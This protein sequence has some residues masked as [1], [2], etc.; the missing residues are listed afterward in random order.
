M[1]DVFQAFQT[2]L[3]GGFDY[4]SLAV[5]YSV[6][7]IILVLVYKIITMIFK[8]ILYSFTKTKKERSNT[9]VFFHLWRYVYIA[10]SILILMFATTGSFEGLGY[11]TALLSAAIGWALQRPITGIA[12]WF[13][14]VVSKPFRI[15]DRI[16]IGALKGDVINITL[17]H[18]YI[19]EIGG[20]IG[21]DERSGRTILVPN[22]VLF[23]SNIINYT[24]T[25]DFIM[26]E[27]SVVITHKSNLEK[28]KKMW[29]EA[30]VNATKKFGEKSA[31]L[32]TRTFFHEDGM[33][34][35]VRYKTHTE[36]REKVKSDIVQGIYEAVKRSKDVEFAY[37][38]SVVAEQ[39][40]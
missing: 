12:G 18:I 34:L 13:M 40:L 5:Y 2:F 22:S 30:A 29:M 25:D 6:I 31:S 3:S 4:I 15:G 39:K 1:N 26:D 17:T 37:H 23:E 9:I 28:A 7:I 11:S 14:I 33:T 24:H 8:R 20:T 16:S 27:V 10:F 35:I 21:G 32:T 38:H 19:G 36:E